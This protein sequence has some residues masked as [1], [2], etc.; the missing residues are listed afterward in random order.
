MEVRLPN[1]PDHMSPGLRKV[2]MFVALVFGVRVA[3]SEMRCAPLAGGWVG[4]QPEV[5][6]VQPIVSSHLRTLRRLGVI[7]HVG[8]V[9]RRDDKRKGSETTRL[10]ALGVATRGEPF[11]CPPGASYIEGF[12]RSAEPHEPATPDADPFG[13]VEDLGA[14]VETEV[15][16]DGMAGG[17]FAPED[18]TSRQGVV[19]GGDDTPTG[20]QTVR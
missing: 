4:R 5:D 13:E 17:T 2:A 9:P 12:I 11:A 1:L 18:C 3:A 14:V 7:T 10:Y 6:M 15:R 16:L 8:N 20:G 19:H